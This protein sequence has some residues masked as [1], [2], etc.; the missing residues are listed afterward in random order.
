[1]M[2]R[3]LLTTLSFIVMESLVLYVIS[4]VLAG[5]A[6]GSGPAYP[7]VLLAMLGGYGLVRGLLRFDL[8]VPALVVLGAGG[9]VLALTVLLNVQYNTGGNPL[10]FSWFTG[11]ANSPDE[12]LQ[13][14]WP[15]T[16]GVLVICAGWVRGVWIAQRDMTYGLVLMSF[17][18]GLV[19][20]VITL[21]FGQS[22]HAGDLINLAALPFFLSGLFTL[23][24]IQLQVAEESGGHA[25]RGPWMQVVLGTVAGLGVISALLGLFP[26]GLANRLLAPVGLL[27]LRIIDLLIYAIAL[28]VSWIVTFL[29][30]RLVNENSEWRVDTRFATDTAEQVEEQG[31][32]SVFIGFLLTLFKFLFV[33][34]V[35]AIVAFILYRIFRRLRRPTTRTGDEVREAID[36][37]G[38]LGRDLN[39]LFR[40]LMNRW[41]RGGAEKEPDLPPNA[42]RVRRMYLDLLEDAEG[43]GAPR[44]PAATPHE[45]APSLSET[46]QAAGPVRLSDRFA[47]ARYGREEPT[48]EEVAALEREV[49]AAKRVSTT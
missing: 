28:P 26:L 37:E 4:L 10:S 25:A 20:F 3:G 17:S 24:L 11:F 45:F 21:L 35:V 9:T 41:R 42:R 33:L 48:A 23:A 6:G 15:Q 49:E 31:D 38:G 29:L 30:S 43:R 18:I 22:T 8:S 5:G 2:K 14:R 40:G 44:P 13:S 7:T 46:Y 32:Q 16:W 34:L 27:V 1:M 19:I 36:A 47:G 39:A 12:Y